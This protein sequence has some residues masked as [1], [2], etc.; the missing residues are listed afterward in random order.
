MIG[1]ESKESSLR[2]QKMVASEV[3]GLKGFAIL[4]AGALGI[5]LLTVLLFLPLGLE[6]QQEVG[7]WTAAIALLGVGVSLLFILPAM[8]DSPPPRSVLERLGD[9]LG[10][11]IFLVTAIACEVCVVAIVIVSL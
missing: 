11:G 6:R 3:A 1:I 2:G 10:K 7:G 8:G 9:L 4:T 5:G